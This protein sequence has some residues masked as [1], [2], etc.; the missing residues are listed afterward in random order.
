MLR[1]TAVRD[2]VDGILTDVVILIVAGFLLESIH[3]ELKV[4]LSERPKQRIRLIIEEIDHLG[5]RVEVCWL[6]DGR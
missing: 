1:G 5:T 6:T 3:K 4:G 2:H